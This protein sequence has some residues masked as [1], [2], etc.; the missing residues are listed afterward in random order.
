MDPN[1]LQITYTEETNTRY[2][3]QLFA[4]GD[5]YK[6]M[7]CGERH[8]PVRAALA[9][10]DKQGV[11]IFGTDRLGARH[12]LAVAYGARS[13]S[14]GPGQRVPQPGI[15]VFLGGISAITADGDVIIQRVIEFIRTIPLSRST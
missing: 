7:G 1:T 9:A 2:P 11:F 8:S 3:I 15:G 10:E 12:G 13:H 6:L 14:H 4:H 5:K